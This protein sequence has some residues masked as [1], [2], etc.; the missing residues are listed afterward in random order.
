MSKQGPAAE[1]KQNQAP[2]AEP[3][4]N[5]SEMELAPPELLAGS[6][7]ATGDSGNIDSQAALLGGR[8]WQG[9]QR[10]MLAAQIGRLY[11]NR[12]LQRVSAAL[13]QRQSGPGG[14]GAAGAID[15]ATAQQA[16]AQKILT[17]TYGKVK[18]IIPAKIEALADGP[19]KAKFV[20]L[21]IREKRTN[22]HTQQPWKPEDAQTL[23]R[24]DGFADHDI[25]TIYI[26]DDPTGGADDQVPVVVHEMLH[27]NAGGG[28]ASTMGADIDEGTTEYLTIKA[29]AQAGVSIKSPAYQSQV[30]LVTLLVQ[31][32][33]EGTL[34][35]AFFN[36][37]NTL[38][39][40]FE[41]V[42]GEGTWKTFRK[43]LSEGGLSKAES[44]LKA[45]RSP[46][47]VKEK[48]KLVNELLNGWVTDDDLESIR[49]IFSSIDDKEGKQAIREAVAPRVTELIDHGQ[50]AKLR[51]ILGL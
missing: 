25:Q 45:P 10:Q 43:R 37:P 11:G 51:L 9:A 13:I 41:T 23:N 28:F 50:R 19:L 29:C 14:G 1:T 39:T 32:I 40:M 26:L 15:K 22:P 7:L 16:K 27:T 21:Q 42:R 12:H 6:R 33:G 47:W 24:L 46:D 20:E 4:A 2:K 49:A 3:V 36:S 35:Q 5:S 18:K 31:V 38:I 17:E 48:I 44:F 34:T 8:P 30:S